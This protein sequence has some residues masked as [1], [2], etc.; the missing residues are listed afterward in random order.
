[1]RAVTE[2]DSGRDRTGCVVRGE[3]NASL[4]LWMDPDRSLNLRASGDDSGETV[5]D[6]FFRVK[7]SLLSTMEGDFEPARLCDCPTEKNAGE[8][9][10]E[11]PAVPGGAD[12]LEAVLE[13]FSRALILWEIPEPRFTFLTTGNVVC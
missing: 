13:S 5:G 3:L 6:V 7:D 9:P 2:M 8:T 1:M 10:G 12:E 4:L 11:G